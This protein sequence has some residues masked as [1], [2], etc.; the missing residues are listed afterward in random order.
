LGLSL[1]QDIALFLG[2]DVKLASSPRHGSTFTVS[3]PTES[4][5]FPYSPVFTDKLDHLVF[6]SIE[7]ELLRDS[8]IEW[9]PVNHYKTMQFISIQNVKK[10]TK[11]AKIE[12]IFF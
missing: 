9:L 11:S 6:Y 5:L 12:A 7:D 3:L 4:I 10:A 2:G 1:V 8:T